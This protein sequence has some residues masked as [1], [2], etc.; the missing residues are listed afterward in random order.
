[1]APKLKGIPL[2]GDTHVAGP[3]AAGRA[4]SCHSLPETAPAWDERGFT[5]AV[6]V[7]F[8][9]ALDNDGGS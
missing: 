9:G 8:A 3:V 5:Y 6:E 7:D 4:V 1:M 2:G